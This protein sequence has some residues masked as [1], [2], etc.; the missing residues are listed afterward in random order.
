MEGKT[1]TVIGATGLIGSCLVKLLQTDDDFVT[2]KA[3]VRR[4]FEFESPKIQVKVIDFTDGTAFRTAIAGSDA[5]FCAVGTTQKKVKGDKAE[6]RK[7]DYDIP[8]HAAQ[9]CSETGCPHFLLVSS[10][11]ASRVSGNFYLK[12]KGEVEDTIRNMNIPS[13]SVFR[14]SMLLGKRE[15][16]RFGEIIAKAL[17]VPFSFL[18][19]SKYKPIKADQVARAMIAASK[20][21]KPGFH[22]YHYREMIELK[23]I[24]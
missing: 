5:I 14:P 13:V 16:F 4:P 3:L 19:T 22:V 9:F 21:D 12:L 15:E 20:K 1:A 17:S 11:G 24:G 10:L 6:Y 7:V 2:I 8:V 18:F 23:F